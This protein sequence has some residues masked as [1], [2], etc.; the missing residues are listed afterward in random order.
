MIIICFKTETEENIFFNSGKLFEMPELKNIFYLRTFEKNEKDR[1][2]LRNISKGDTT[3]SLD[4][5]NISYWVVFLGRQQNL[6][7]VLKINSTIS[8]N[9]PRKI[10]TCETSIKQNSKNHVIKTK[11]YFL[12]NIFSNENKPVLVYSHNHKIINALMDSTNLSNE[13]TISIYSGPN[14]LLEEITTFKANNQEDFS[15]GLRAS[16]SI[17]EKMKVGKRFWHYTYLPII[18]SYKGQSDINKFAKKL[19]G[20]NRTVSNARKC[21]LIDL[22]LL[23][24]NELKELRLGLAYAVAER[25]M[26]EYL[27]IKAF[28]Y[29]G[30]NIAPAVPAESLGTFEALITKR[31]ELEVFDSTES[32]KQFNPDSIGTLRATKKGAK[33]ALIFCID[34]YSKATG[35]VQ[36]FLGIESE[37]IQRNGGNYFA[38]Y[39]SK[40]STQLRDKT[41][42]ILMVNDQE[43]TE[44]S[45]QQIPKFL[46]WL[47]LQTQLSNNSLSIGLHSLLGHS[48]KDI[49]AALEGSPDIKS[50][51]YIHDYYAFCTSIKLMRNDWEY[52]AAPSVN[53]MSCKFC[54]H[55]TQRH[56]H[57]NQIKTIIDLPQVNLVAPSN[58]VRNFWLENYGNEKEIIVFPHSHLS[59]PEKL[60]TKDLRNE[61]IRVAFVGY[62]IK[63]KGWDEYLEVMTV[64]QK[65][66]ITFYVASKEDPKLQGIEF[67]YLAQTQSDVNKTTQL[68]MD[69]QIDLVF[70]WPNW[71]ETYSYV[72]MESIAAG[73]L[74]VTNNNSGNVKFLAEEF[75][76]ALSYDSLNGFC[77]EINNGGILEILESKDRYTYEH[78]HDNFLLD[79]LKESK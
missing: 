20:I 73:C 25:R 29:F 23:T 53:S 34:N 8:M 64:N 65:E 72:T 61:N 42:L 39:P 56:N 36:L 28:N 55:G 71:P 19:L 4:D 69:H 75:N 41:N 59:L 77:E 30:R 47:K 43:V 70:I 79:F 57:F 10:Y 27:K 37:K 12:K 31:L 14:D 68:L 6:D 46:E 17:F 58:F 67:L 16:A 38:L 22:T 44:F 26:P 54:I 45:S 40:F 7:F 33:N 51:F 2:I 15:N 52:C 62:P 78:I 11:K 13:Q 9:N 50:N 35:G 1:K 49:K 18:S 60:D 32:E 3:Y 76:V 21:N 5:L 24:N 66:N 63:T 74:V 48:A